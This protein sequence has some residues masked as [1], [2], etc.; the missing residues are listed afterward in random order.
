M[1]NN[2]S[3][4]S[5]EILDFLV[6][7]KILT[8]PAFRRKFGPHYIDH[9]RSLKTLQYIKFPNGGSGIRDFEWDENNSYAIIKITPAGKG[10]YDSHCERKTDRRASRRDMIINRVIGLAGLIVAIIGTFASIIISLSLK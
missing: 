5:L 6:K 1:E 4:E 3:S 8:I 2:L 7:H 10:I 9:L